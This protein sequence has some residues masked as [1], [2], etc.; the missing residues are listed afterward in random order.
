MKVL[1]SA[2]P[3]VGDS[4][5]SWVAGKQHKHKV[6]A[7]RTV[8]GSK[9]QVRVTPDTRWAKDGWDDIGR[10]DTKEVQATS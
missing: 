10:F 4:L 3:K 8:D 7:I 9:V 1:D 5:F 2:G 6:L